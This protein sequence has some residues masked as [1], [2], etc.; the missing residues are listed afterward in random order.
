VVWAVKHEN[1]CSTEQAAGTE[2]FYFG[3]VILFF[4]ASLVYAISMPTY[5]LHYCFLQ[6]TTDLLTADV[7]YYTHG[8]TSD[9]EELTGELVVHLAADSCL[10]MVLE[11]KLSVTVSI[12]GG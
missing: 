10:K 8:E 7:D 2:R 3:Q 4:I 12:A 5:Q 6:R 11:W 1:E 9:A